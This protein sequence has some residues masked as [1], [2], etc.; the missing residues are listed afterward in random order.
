MNLDPTPFT[1]DTAAA[2]ILAALD[3]GKWRKA[4]DGAKEL[5]KKDKGRYGALLIAA[6]VGLAEELIAKGL[7]SEATQVIDYLKNIA[8]PETVAQLKTEWEKPRAK[9][10]SAAV[11]AGTESWQQV[12]ALAVQLETAAPVPTEAWARVDALVVRRAGGSPGLPGSPEAR[13]AQELASVRAA[14]RATA[15]GQWEEAQTALRDLPRRSVFQH[16]RMLLRGIRLAHLGESAEAQLCFQRLPAHTATARA[17]TLWQTWRGLPVSDSALSLQRSVALSRMV[18]STEAIGRAVHVAERHS[19]ADEYLEVYETL[20]PALRENF[21]TDVPGLA[22]LLSAVA[23]PFSPIHQASSDKLHIL[24]QELDE[25][26][27]HD[28]R[29]PAHLRAPMLQCLM[30][31][32]MRSTVRDTER[33]FS[34]LVKLLTARYGRNPIRDA[35]IWA[36]CGEK[37]SQFTLPRT[38]F[39]MFRESPAKSRT[40]ELIEA[41]YVRAV[42]LDPD[43][44]KIQLRLLRF[45]EETGNKSARG[46][47]AE[48]L[49]A[50]FPN[51]KQGLFEAGRLAVSRKAF[52]KGIEFLKRARQ[53]DPLDREIVGELVAAFIKHARETAKKKPAGVAKIWAELDTIKPAQDRPISVES[54]LTTSFNPT[55]SRWA[56]LAA[57]ALIEPDPAISGAYQE[58]ACRLAPSPGVALTY[59]AILATHWAIRL[60][61]EATAYVKQRYTFT[62]W[63]DAALC[64]ALWPSRDQFIKC[65]ANDGLEN[66]ILQKN[67]RFLLAIP[68]REP[69]D[70]DPD[71]LIS[72]GRQMEKVID[73]DTDDD[74]PGDLPQAVQ[75]FLLPARKAL[76]LKLNEPGPSD[77][78]LQLAQIIFGSFMGRK[79]LRESLR[80][81]L[82]AIRVQA[83][84]AGF[85]ECATLA[86]KIL[87]EYRFHPDAVVPPLLPGE[88]TVAWDEDFDLFRHGENYE[89]MARRL[90]TMSPRDQQLAYHKFGSEVQDVYVK[91]LRAEVRRLSR[92]SES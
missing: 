55:G 38:F 88:D 15:Q 86:Q 58:E 3:Q 11:Q 80:G 66:Q 60:P 84:A 12:I 74:W 8:P 26:L 6:N 33:D 67:V 59:T 64:I 18:G 7:L 42:K 25:S 31:I 65:S 92:K 57:Q 16:W 61:E 5:W 83:A 63:S 71:G 90:I 49:I 87:A 89:P 43:N 82:D 29:L 91:N 17:A 45:Y 76:E 68:S 51:Q 70:A 39:D 62:T 34:D 46:K 14:C 4:R 50:R 9:P 47:Q 22:Q 44:E 30:S 73:P 36:A 27:V 48:A 20:M 23:L 75:K 40:P 32:V 79:P 13:V 77:S 28:E 41:A 19:R 52:G 2:P 56:I 21:A 54:L 78:R 53:L 1:G 37:L 72:L 35:L 85:K 10:V 69:I 81:A 24:A